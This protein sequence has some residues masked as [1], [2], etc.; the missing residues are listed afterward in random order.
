MLDE[1]MYNKMPLRSI[2]HL[3]GSVTRTRLLRT[4]LNNSE[5]SFF[6]RELSRTIAMQLNAVRRELLNLEAFGLVQTKGVGQ[7]KF[8]QLNH[9]NIIFPELKA[10]ILKSQLLLENGIMRQIDALGAVGLLLL[11]GKFVGR[12]DAPADMLIVGRV[13]RDEL[14]DVVHGLQIDFG[15]EIN[16]TVMTPKEYTYRLEVGDKFLYSILESKRIMLIDRIPKT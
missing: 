14:R 11:T 3:F 6:V 15:Y 8:Y 16:Y 7:K 4:F 2:E 1:Q 10:L 13:N 9:E 12:T 5:K